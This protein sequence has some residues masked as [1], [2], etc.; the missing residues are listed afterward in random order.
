MASQP[1]SPPATEVPTA[2]QRSSEGVSIQQGVGDLAEGNQPIQ[3]ATAVPNQ[4]S[5]IAQLMGEE[6]IQSPPQ[7]PDLPVQREAM[8]EDDNET[9]DAS[10]E[11]GSELSS[12]EWQEKL[13]QN[14]QG[15]LPDGDDESQLL[16]ESFLA[17]AAGFE[18]DFNE[19]FAGAVTERVDNDDEFSETTQ[20]IQTETPEFTGEEFFEFLEEALLEEDEDFQTELAESIKAADLVILE[21]LALR[22][23]D[24][25]D[26]FLEELAETIL[27]ADVE[28][29]EGEY[30]SQAEAAYEIEQLSREVYTLVR[31]RINRD[32]ERQG[33]YYAGR[34]AW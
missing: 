9:D 8:A 28:F 1:V 7:Q 14:L 27:E 31:Q 21:A 4:W 25:D 16:L 12:D 17:K 3:R 10:T 13:R 11:D 2:A 32:R 30:L 15:A 23:E 22:L 26:E 33:G 5:S 29:P 20:E 24:P 6:S 19:F 34:L 18:T